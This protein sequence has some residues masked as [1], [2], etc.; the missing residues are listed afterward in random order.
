MTINGVR[1]FGKKNETF[2]YPGDFVYLFQPL[3]PYLQNTAVFG[4]ELQICLTSAFRE[5]LFKGMTLEEIKSRKLTPAEKQDA[6]RLSKQ[7]D[8][9]C[10]KLEALKLAE[11]VSDSGVISAAYYG[12]GF[13]PK[14]AKF[15]QD[16]WN[17][18]ICFKKPFPDYQELCD[19]YYTSKISAKELRQKY[20]ALSFYMLFQNIDAWGWEAYVPD[21][22][23][24]QKLVDYLDKKHTRYE[25]LDF[26]R[27]FS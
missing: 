25:R 27:D 6:L 22:E 13:F 5:Q 24:Y 4:S 2:R 15:L 11:N 23:L 18:V 21:Q 19:I 8:E 16:D 3:I 10:E 20:K 9:L 17:T 26:D 7:E 12:P 1:A 14:Y